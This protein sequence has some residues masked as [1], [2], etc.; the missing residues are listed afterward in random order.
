MSY[1][2]ATGST[3]G[4]FQQS[5]KLFHLLADSA[6]VMVWVSGQDQGC[7]FFNQRW[8]DFTGRTMAQEVGNG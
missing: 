8:L 5:E 6:P 2:P 7:V 3:E 1:E 4:M